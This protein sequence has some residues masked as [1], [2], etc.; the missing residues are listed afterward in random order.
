MP[1]RTPRSALLSKVTQS[2]QPQVPT[3]ALVVLHKR[4]RPPAS[5]TAN[6]SGFEE[7]RSPQSHEHKRQRALTFAGEV[8]ASGDAG[9]VVAVP[10]A[11]VASAGI[12][13]MLS[14]DRFAK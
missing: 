2:Q 8:S 9:M 6:V 5:P 14:G 4:S 12:S 7:A 13:G 11:V 1:P 10:D 3:T